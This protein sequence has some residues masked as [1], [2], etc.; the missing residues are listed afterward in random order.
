MSHTT[1]T[2][3]ALSLSAVTLAALVT[4][5]GAEA[6]PSD[7]VTR[8]DKVA[9]AAQD[10]AGEVDPAQRR[11]LASYFSDRAMSDAWQRHPELIARAR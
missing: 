2:H 11:Y 6:D 5:C 9:G 10:Y 8:S 4:A 7:P 1:F 3:L